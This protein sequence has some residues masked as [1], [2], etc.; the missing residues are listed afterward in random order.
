MTP[1]AASSNPKDL[2]VLSLY[3]HW[4]LQALSAFSFLHCHS[5][6]LCVF[7]FQMVWLRSES[8]LATTGFV[9]AVT[10]SDCPY[11]E[12]AE[13]YLCDQPSPEHDYELP[14]EDDGMATDE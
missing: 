6:L 3:Y 12:S 4:A 1:K 8:S 10:K 11:I 13:H 7:I 9:N 5:I 2:L 14:R